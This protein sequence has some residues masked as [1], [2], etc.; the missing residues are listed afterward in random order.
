M[1]VLGYGIHHISDL[2]RKQKFGSS[3]NLWILANSDTQHCLLAYLDNVDESV[4]LSEQCYVGKHACL[5]TWTADTGHIAAAAVVPAV[6]ATLPH[7]APLPCPASLAQA[8]L[9]SA[10]HAVMIRITDIDTL[11]PKLIL[12]TSYTVLSIS[13]PRI[14]DWYPVASYTH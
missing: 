11:H 8:P 10:H 5:P 14:S 2:D 9:H 1:P 7:L 6:Q 12:C 3:L 4:C 13:I